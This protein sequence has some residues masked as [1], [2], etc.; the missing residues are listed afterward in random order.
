MCWEMH[1]R[2]V[3]S[4]NL[5]DIK[6]LFCRTTGLYYYINLYG[7]FVNEGALPFLS[8]IKKASDSRC[9]SMFLPYDFS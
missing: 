1:D 2:D 4:L 5:Y 7:G 3:H 8:F 6:M 9:T